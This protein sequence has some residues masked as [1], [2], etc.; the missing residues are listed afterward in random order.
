M[1]F[2]PSEIES[3]L[4]KVIDN[5][6]LP[7]FHSSGYISKTMKATGE[8][9]R[10]LE[11]KLGDDSG[12]I[13]GRQYSEQ[14]AKGRAPGKRPP[15]SVLKKWAQAKFG[16]GEK[17]ATSIAWAVAKKIEKVGT[18]YHIQGGTDLLEVLEEPR[19]LQFIQEE[20]GGILKNRLAENLIR[21]AQKAF[22]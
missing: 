16:V 13:R 4:Q 7:R 22:A 11:I 6:L 8:W 12:T 19:T 21:N 14:L 5:F 3:V 10:S 20:L 9:E 18:Q 2:E 1:W 17:E 15:I